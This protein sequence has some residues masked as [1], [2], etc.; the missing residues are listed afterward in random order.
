[1]T[2]L[3]NCMKMNDKVMF[4]QFKDAQA[5]DIPHINSYHN[6]SAGNLLSYMYT[7]KLDALSVSL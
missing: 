2:A 1:M 7:I 4:V 6:L 3:A 5:N